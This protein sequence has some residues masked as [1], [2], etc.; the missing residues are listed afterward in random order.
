LGYGGCADTATHHITISDPS[1]TA[2]TYDPLT[3]CNSLLVN[4]K[5]KPPPYAKFTF[6][7]GDGASSTSQDTSF[8]HLFRGPAYFYPS[9]LLTDS[10]GC[11]ASVGGPSA[12][13]VIGAKPLFGADKKAFCDSGNVFF[14]NFTIFNDPVVSYNWS[15][16]DGSTSTQFNPSH[17]YPQP[18]INLVTL[19]VETQAG[20]SDVLT[21]TIRAYR[22]PY[23]DIITPDTICINSPVLFRGR[24]VTADTTTIKWEWN[25]GNGQQSSSRDASGIYNK[26][27]NYTINLRTSV[28]FGCND[29]SSRNIYVAPAPTVVADIDPVIISG[30]GITIPAEYTG[31]I[32]TYNWTP[33]HRLSCTDCPNPYANPIKTTKYRITVT[34]RYGCVAS[35]D[36]T[37]FVVCAD[38]NL[39]MPNTFSPNSD[40]TNDV[41]YPRGT[42][43]FNIKSLRI[44]N[45]WGEMVFEKTNFA[46]NTMSAGW[47]GTYKGQKAPQDTYIYTIDVVCENSE[48]T[49]FKGNVT[50][51]R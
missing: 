34:D 37:I 12:I 49:S 9:L 21:D 3:A 14:T 1:Q 46:A 51:I 4:F 43:L 23:A 40:G 20:C 8:S 47:D 35:D 30:A 26:T 41:F 18:G 33:A 10:T 25:L 7:Y 42:G 13:M 31:N 16:G 27:G 11:L 36:I 22:T 39:F 2:F 48:V 44:F 45:R 19:R 28:E 6:F 29:T 5:V 38:K 24:L 15:F 50:L 17:Y 32:V